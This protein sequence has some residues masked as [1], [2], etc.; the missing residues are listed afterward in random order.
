MDS[1]TNEPTTSRRTSK[2]GLV[3]Y[4]NQL[5]SFVFFLARLRVED[6]KKYQLGVNTLIVL[7]PKELREK[8]QAY[9]KENNIDNLYTEE[10]AVVYDRLWEYINELLES[11]GWIFKKSS[12]DIG[13]D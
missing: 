8:A 10:G 7:L 9:K 1:L 12:F 4:E 2:K 5:S 13:H 3:P 6:I 11:D